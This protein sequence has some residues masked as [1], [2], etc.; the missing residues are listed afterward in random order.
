M[1]WMISRLFILFNVFIFSDGFLL[2]L[3]YHKHPIRKI[4]NINKMQFD[5]HNYLNNLSFVNKNIKKIKINYDKIDK[6]Y[7]IYYHLIYLYILYNYNISL[8]Y[9]DDFN[10]IYYDF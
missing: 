8:L 1:M 5:T 6:L 2:P 7:Y 10:L 3:T 4:N 9:Y